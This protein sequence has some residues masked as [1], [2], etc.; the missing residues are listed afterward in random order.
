MITPTIGLAKSLELPHGAKKN[1]PATKARGAWKSCWLTRQENGLTTCSLFNRWIF[2]VPDREGLLEAVKNAA[3][4]DFEW[5]FQLAETLA[6][7]GNWQ[8]DLWPP[9]MTSWCGELDRE[10]H[11]RVLGYLQRP[12]LHPQHGQSVIEV[13]TAVVRDESNPVPARSTF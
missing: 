1:G 11:R 8:T 4:Q 9:L 13:L 5:G 7:I 2:L 10:Q 6:A 3:T 12:Y